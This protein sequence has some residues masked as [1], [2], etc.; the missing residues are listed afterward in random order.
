M[1]D[2]TPPLRP[3]P[4][5]GHPLIDR[6]QDLTPAWLTAVLR[7]RGVLHQARV[8]SARTRSIGNGMIGLNLRIEL[9]YDRA[10]EGAPASLVAKMSSTRAESRASGATLG[11][12]PRETRFYQE[13][14]PRI[15]SGLAVTHFA[16]VSD[17]GASF[18]LLFE[19]LTPARDGD[20]LAGCEV[21]DAAAAMD[22]A[23]ALHAPLWGDTQVLSL[24]WLQLEFMVRMY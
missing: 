2:R 12:Y 7:A 21:E 8:V 15:R 4:Q 11:L 10:E 14:A 5:A 18:C 24:P 9:D 20:Q 23:A 3:N 1:T 19:D 16:G 22:T 13:I 6:E 17:D